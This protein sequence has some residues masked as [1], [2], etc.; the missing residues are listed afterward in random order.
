MLLRQSEFLCIIV[1][2]EC[3]SEVRNAL[4]SDDSCQVKWSSVMRDNTVP[5]ATAG[6]LQAR[7]E[8]QLNVLGPL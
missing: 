3:T 4:M 1:G 7:S 5:P 6:V 2:Y 8:H